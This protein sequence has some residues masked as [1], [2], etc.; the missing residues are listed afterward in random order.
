MW[1][2]A[3]HEEVEK[4]SIVWSA[5]IGGTPR[6]KITSHLHFGLVAEPGALPFIV[7][8]FQL[9]ICSA[10][11]CDLQNI[12][13][14]HLQKHRLSKVRH[15]IIHNHMYCMPFFLGHAVTQE[16]PCSAPCFTATNKVRQ[17]GRP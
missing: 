14:N 7:G 13:S 11:E 8:P 4:I 17:H 3:G 6:P 1:S 15:V 5:Q 9:E 2:C 16:S 10:S 12:G